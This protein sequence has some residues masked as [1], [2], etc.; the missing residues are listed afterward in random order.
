MANYKRDIE[1]LKSKASMFWPEEFSQKQ[2]ELSVIPKLLETQ[3]QFIAILSVGVSS[4]EGLCKLIE[5]STFPANLFLKHLVVLSD[6]GGEMLQRVDTQ[7]TWFFPEDSLEYI[8]QGRTRI[9]K[10]RKLPVSGTLN[11]D[12]LGISGKK[13]LRIEP[14]DDLKK[15]VMAILLF[16]SMSIDDETARILSKCEIG[17]YLGEPDKLEKY[18]CPVFF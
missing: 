11:N 2:S 3:D 18:I 17:N 1:Q 7:F 14:F 12:K 13:L 10:F 8:W 9:H 15:D 4:L 6:F 16:G 5:S